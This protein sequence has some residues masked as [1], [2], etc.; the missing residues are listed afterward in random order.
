MHARRG[1]R[2]ADRP[3][4]ALDDLLADGEAD[5]GARELVPTAK[6]E[7]VTI[8]LRIYMNTALSKRV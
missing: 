3:A 7:A 2:D 6:A 8:V 1:R 4:V 5:A